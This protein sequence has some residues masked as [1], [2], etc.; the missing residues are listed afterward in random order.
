MKKRILFLSAIDLKEKSI[1]VIRK[2]PEAFADRGWDVQYI[3]ARDTARKGNYSYERIINPL[4]VDMDRFIWPFPHL[5]DKVK[6]RWLIYFLDKFAGIIV[7]FQLFLHGARA[8]RKGPVDIIYGYEIYGVL[9]VR[10]LRLFRRTGSAKIVSRF[11][12]TWLTEILEK[13]QIARL[14]ANIDHVIA[15][16]TKSDLA[17]MTDDGTRGNLAMKKLNASTKNLKFWVNGTDF[18]SGVV[19]R[20]AFR[21][22]LGI[23]QKTVILLSVSR[24][25]HWKRLDRGIATAAALQRRGLDFVYIVVGGGSQ[26]DALE[27]LAVKMGVS[28]RIRFAGP[29]PQ[30]EIFNYMNVADF[31]ISMYDLSNVGNPLLEAIRMNKIIVTLKNGSTGSWIQH[32]YNGLIYDPSSSIP[33]DASKDIIYL[34]ENTNARENIIDRIRSTSE[35]KLWTWEDR[36][37]EEVNDVYAL[38]KK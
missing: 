34:I 38:T 3:V 32:K 36:M 7:I 37:S 24:L 5:R 8:L 22:A 25:E 2:T 19:P 18:P 9:A 26:R 23:D 6:G 14:I 13:R 10:L 4:G 15:L 27:K 12:G 21:Q 35:N 29:V 33:D 16:R 30:S 17:I 1:Q 28:D 31:F 20:E 11:Q